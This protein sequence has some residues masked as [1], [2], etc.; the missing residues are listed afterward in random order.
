M[1]VR[2]EVDGWGWLHAPH[3]FF[4]TV[5]FRPPS[6]GPLAILGHIFVSFVRN[7]RAHDGCVHLL[8]GSRPPIGAIVFSLFIRCVTRVTIIPCTRRGEQTCLPKKKLTTVGPPVRRVLA[9]WTRTGTPDGRARIGWCEV[10]RG[11]GSRLPRAYLS[12][13]KGR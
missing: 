13:S 3:L 1:T 7:R 8:F 12:L 9:R 11:W 4:F 10:G 5:T 6:R 2:V